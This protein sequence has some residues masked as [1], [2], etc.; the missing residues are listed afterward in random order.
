MMTAIFSFDIFPP[1]RFPT[2]ITP[3]GRLPL[4]RCRAEAKSIGA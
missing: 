2:E 3:T 4:H 1:R